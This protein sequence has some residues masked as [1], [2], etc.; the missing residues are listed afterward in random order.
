MSIGNTEIFGQEIPGMSNIQVTEYL[1][2]THHEFTRD[3]M[4]EISDLLEQAKKELPHP[5]IEL[6]K[7]SAIWLDYRKEMAAHLEEEEKILFPWIEKLYEAENKGEIV[8]EPYSESVRRMMTEHKHHEDQM[9][10][11]RKLGERLIKVSGQSPILMSLG[12]KLK[13]LDTDLRE[14]MRIETE[15][16]FPRIL[17]STERQ[18]CFGPIP[19]VHEP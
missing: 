14:H 11:I 3:I 7:L 17:A 10:V 15:Y 16:L 9:E 18:G 1:I 5:P 2:A 6:V 8:A 13:Q 19:S 12:Y 4:A